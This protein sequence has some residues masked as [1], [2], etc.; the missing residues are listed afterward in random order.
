M[1]TQ[2]TRSCG[3][4]SRTPERTPRSPRTKTAPAP[5]ADKKDDAKKEDKKEAAPKKEGGKK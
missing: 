4:A 3:A 5:T 1:V 2:A